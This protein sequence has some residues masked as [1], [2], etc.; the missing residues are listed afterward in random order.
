MLNLSEKKEQNENMIADNNY[1]KNR[2]VTFSLSEILKKRQLN[3][4][5]SN[6]FTGNVCTGQAFDY[7]ILRRK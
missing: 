7:N 1:H 6:W 5:N 2:C 3:E 4:I